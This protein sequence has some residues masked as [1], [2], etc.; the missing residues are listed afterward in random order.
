MFR[1]FNF[2]NFADLSYREL[3]IITNFKSFFSQKLESVEAWNADE[4]FPLFFIDDTVCV[5]FL[6]VV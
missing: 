2:I 3:N 4:V 5:V 1:Y 6:F